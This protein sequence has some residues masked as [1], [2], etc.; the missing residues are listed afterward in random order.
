MWL[1]GR[2][3]P[4]LVGD[5]VPNDDE[6]WANFLLMMDIVDRL[7]CTQVTEDDA[8]YLQW[9]INDHHKAFAFLYP[10]Y[11]LIPKMHFM[12]HMPRFMIL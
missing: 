11:S 9:L 7:F 10:E 5:N 12:I 3:L 1:L 8:V 4:L 2:I 6:K